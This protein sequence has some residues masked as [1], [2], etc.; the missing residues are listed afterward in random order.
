MV[1]R[2]SS[3]MHIKKQDLAK[4]IPCMGSLYRK[5]WETWSFLTTLTIFRLGS[6]NLW[7]N[8]KNEQTAKDVKWWRMKRLPKKMLIVR[9][10]KMITYFLKVNR[11]YLPVEKWW[12]AEKLTNRPSTSVNHPTLICFHGRKL[13]WEYKAAF[14][15]DVGATVGSTRRKPWRQMCLRLISILFQ[16]SAVNTDAHLI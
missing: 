5:V 8:S 6:I 9:H 1:L 15:N 16:F 3:W 12:E 11:L 14:D 10:R 13:T 7:D 2:C 4:F